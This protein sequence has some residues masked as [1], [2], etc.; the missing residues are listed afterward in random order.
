MVL[1]KAL[2]GTVSFGDDDDDVGPAMA[3]VKDI[4]SR[5]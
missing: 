5:R 3:D 1:A 2:I 4:D